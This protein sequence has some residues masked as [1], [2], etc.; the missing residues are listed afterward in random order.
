[1]KTSKT[2]GSLLAKYTSLSLVDIS[3]LLPI[4][5]AELCQR[6]RLLIFIAYPYWKH[7]SISWL[8]IIKNTGSAYVWRIWQTHTAAQKSY[9]LRS[10]SDPF[11]RYAWVYTKC[12]N[13]CYLS[14]YIR[15]D[16]QNS[17]LWLCSKLKSYLLH[18]QNIILQIKYY[19][20]KVIPLPHPG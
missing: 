1:M 12:N 14:R 8:A 20:R 11:E 5:V 3:L 16:L 7:F 9:R 13:F 15:F 18:I 6:D 10:C 19:E 17:G 2:C 4:G